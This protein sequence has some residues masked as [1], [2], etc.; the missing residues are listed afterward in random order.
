M[1]RLILLSTLS[2][3]LISNNY[4]QEV[5]TTAGDH[6]IAS[7]G[8]LSW[9]LGEVITETYSIGQNSLT[10]GFNQSQLSATATYE[11][12][13]L[14]FNLKA[15]PNPTSDYIILETDK[16]KKMNYHVYNQQGK[17]IIQSELTDIQTKIDF[18]EFI[19]A[20]YIIKI[21]ENNIPLKQ[22]KI[23]KQ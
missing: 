21:F 9:T 10:Q 16:V 18:Q 4:A 15:Y 6:H 22:F 14:N 3:F 20:I 7:T 2:L 23:V 5:I 11:L 17:L 1:K 19:P 8:S 12:P 13:G